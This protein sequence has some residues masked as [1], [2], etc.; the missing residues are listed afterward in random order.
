MA[1][2]QHMPKALS[3][4]CDRGLQGTG[5]RSTISTVGIKV[6]LGLRTLPTVS[7]SRLVTLDKK[8]TYL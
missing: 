2:P 4:K 6:G 1:P 3:S 8:N 7:L 5:A